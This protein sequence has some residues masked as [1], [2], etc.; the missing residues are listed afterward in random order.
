LHSRANSAEW[1]KVSCD[2]VPETL[3]D[4][5]VC[6]AASDEQS[7]IVAPADLHITDSSMDK[8]QGIEFDPVHAAHTL[9]KGVPWIIGTRAAH[10]NH[11][12]RA[13]GSFMRSKFQIRFV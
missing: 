1:A 7:A 12:D 9:P 4:Q 6:A 13:A 2:D 10:A 11:I 8:R 5:G 3:F